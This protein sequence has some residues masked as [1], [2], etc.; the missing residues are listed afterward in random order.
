MIEETLS[1]REAQRFYDAYGRKLEWGDPFEARAKARALG[2]AAVEAGE[3]VLELGVGTGR[4]QAAALAW[5][6]GLVVGLDVSSTM[7]GLARE[8]APRAHPL[9]GTA[10]ALPF[11]DGSFDLVFSTYTFDLLALRDVELALREAR[12]VLRPG[13]RLAACSLTEGRTLAQRALIGA[14]KGIHR[15]LGAARVGGCRP[16]EL[17]ELVRAAGFRVEAD[18]HVAQLGIPSEVVLARPALD[19]DAG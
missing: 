1:Q 4:F 18:E 9:R 6:A 8:A 2:L 12:R 14:W 16:L 11:A 15:W 3:R 13:G 5:G 17:S 7:L 10:T 19:A